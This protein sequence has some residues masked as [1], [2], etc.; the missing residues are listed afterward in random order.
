MKGARPLSRQEV[1]DIGR[2]LRNN[3]ERALFFLLLYTGARISEALAL[4]IGDVRRPGED[5]GIRRQITFQK[6]E[7]K[8]QRT[9]RA[10]DVHPDLAG[11]LRLLLA[12]LAG[13]GELAPADPLFRS[14]TT[15]GRWSRTAAW[16]ALRVAFEAA[17][18]GEDRVS[19]HSF[20]KTFAQ[21]LHL[22]G[23]RVEIIQELLGHAD[24]RDTMGYVAIDPAELA[25]AVADLPSE[26]DD[27][28][29][30]A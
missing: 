3:R 13:A 29:P 4:T 17:G 23:Y 7:T 20:R 9:S 26:S 2:Q 15:G 6:R 30:E 5:L 21:R 19:P 12:E 10:I 22:L 1:Q 24:I 18:L 28:D 16:R 27:G 25:R 14:S 8:N 11:A